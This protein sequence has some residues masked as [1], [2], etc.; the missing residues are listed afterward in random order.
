MAAGGWQVYY[1]LVMPLSSIETLR[2]R[3]DKA[4][5][6]ER[7]IGEQLVGQGSQKQRPGLIDGKDSCRAPPSGTRFRLRK[8]REDEESV[9]GARFV[10]PSSGQQ[11]AGTEV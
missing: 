8:Q 11:G 3:G 1:S 5:M 10:K 6:W 7:C 4:M 2:V 9:P